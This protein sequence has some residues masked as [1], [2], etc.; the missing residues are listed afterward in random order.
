MGEFLI[1]DADQLGATSSCVS[2]FWRR[3]ACRDGAVLSSPGSSVFPAHGN[4]LRFSLPNRFNWPEAVDAESVRDETPWLRGVS[5]WRCK[6]NRPKTGHVPPR[7]WCTVRAGN[8]S[9][10]TP[11]AGSPEPPSSAGGA[12]LV[13]LSKPRVDGRWM[14]HSLPHSASPSSLSPTPLHRPAPVPIWRQALSVR[15]FN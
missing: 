11:A 1:P 4:V 3:M 6:T 12:P 5:Q 9:T 8:R 10:T 15:P 7:R 13:V 2:W 14:D